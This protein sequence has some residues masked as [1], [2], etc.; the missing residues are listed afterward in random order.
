VTYHFL[1]GWI[2][3]TRFSINP[4][5]LRAFNRPDYRKTWKMS[6][7]NV[8]GIHMSNLYIVETVSWIFKSK[9]K[10]PLVATAGYNLMENYVYLPIHQI[11][12]L[13]K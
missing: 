10:N 4:A 7:L 6:V 2:G 9:F 3:D 12:K 1:V 5:P 13:F 11:L 8:F